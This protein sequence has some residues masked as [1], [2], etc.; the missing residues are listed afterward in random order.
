MTLN[1]EL[2]NEQEVVV[3]ATPDS[4]MVTA[5]GIEEKQSAFGAPGRGN[6]TP[7]PLGHSR[8]YCSKCRSPYDLPDGATTWRCAGCHT[9]NSTTPGECEWCAIL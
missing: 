2:P 5:V 8:F 9:F 7:I 3:T 4:D 6:E 1:K